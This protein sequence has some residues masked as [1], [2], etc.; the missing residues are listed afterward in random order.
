MRHWA[1]IGLSVFGAGLFFFGVRVLQVNPLSFGEPKW[2]LGSL[3]VILFTAA[4]CIEWWRTEYPAKLVHRLP[5]ET[6]SPLADLGSRASSAPA[7]HTTSE[8]TVRS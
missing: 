6:I 8:A 4:R 5:E 1:S 7:G 2:L 3:V